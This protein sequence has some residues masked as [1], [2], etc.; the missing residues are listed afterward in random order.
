MSL[1]KL[2]RQYR[3]KW[4][5]LPLVLPTF[6]LPIS[7]WANTV[8]VLNGN[9]VS[10][11]YLPLGLVLSLMLFFGWA[12]LPGIVIGLLCSIT[13]GMT[14]EDSVGV[15]FHFLIPTVLCW[16][17]YRIF[18][19]RR[20][21]ISHGN[22]GLMPHRLFWQMLLP[23]LIF[24]VLSQLAEYLGIH[25]RAT[26]LLGINP[27][28]LRTLITFQALM[29]GCLTGIPLCYFLIR[30]IR[31]PL[32]IRGFI[33]QIRLQID[34][35]IKRFE[36]VLWAAVLLILLVLLLMPLNSSSTIFSTNYTLSLLMPVMLWG[37]MRFG[38]RFVSLVWS[39]VL[40][41]IIHF[42][43]RYLPLSPIY[44]NQLAITSSSYLVFSFIIAYMAMLAT[45]QRAIYAR[46]RRMAFLD[47]V[48]H[49]PNLRALGRELNRSP[50]SVLCLLRIPELE[51]L[52]RHYGVL[53]RIQYKQHLAESLGELLMPGEDVYQMA[54][55]ELVIRLNSEDHQQRIPLLYEHLK[56]FR[57][58][59]NGMPLQPPV[60]FSYCN[61][62]SPVVHLHLLLGELNSAADLSLVT[63]NPENLQR[64]GAINL[65]QE[66]KDKVTMMNL[67]VKALE[68]DRFI[69]M[70]QPIV[71]IRGDSYHEVL[72]RM[73]DDS[74]KIIMP[75]VFLPVAHEFG[76]SARIDSWV[77]EHTLIFMDKQRKKLPG[78]RLA[79]NI[80]PFSVS[81][82]HF[83]HQV[84]ALLER[85]DIEPWQIIFELTE[86][87]SLTN[88]EQARQT[89]AHLQDMGCRVAIDDF[90]TGYASY[91]RLKTM[92]ADLL[93]I[94]G[95]FIR[96]LLTSS[97]DYQAV[98][99]ICL[100][101]RMKNMQ[102]VAEYV[103]TA[104]IRQ[105]VISLG[106]DYM[107][108]YDIGKPAPLERLADG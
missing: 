51:I 68:Q 106:I 79:I 97:L 9:D 3:D 73:L 92:N 74:D 84:K 48:V 5:A 57:F 59:W 107:Q 55:H 25:P 29:A 96:N 47:P 46:V 83:H 100:L 103:E 26:G 40:I 77:L 86:N 21:Q 39:P 15:I 28:S 38:Y 11:Y 90:G 60:G 13:R 35:K 76:L 94:D 2:Y 89:L 1:I 44:N 75:D 19:P 22:V 72:L 16:G 88:P 95:S 98:A 108:G 6:L 63:G 10:L 7:R 93:K 34:P 78:M 82:S 42:H 65:Q 99:S 56:K 12:A 18:V 70:A 24:L 91:A 53:L 66:L 81:N 27:F 8:A 61:V 20:Q 85:Y 37:A 33:S 23:S 87:H 80:S 32:Y 4:W 104:E 49:L 45:Q 50:W 64:R 36:I 52:G 31:N 43:Y 30:I 58:V 54:G 17:G 62:R 101:A 69:L 41:V 67:L 71:G 102:V 105:A 14:L